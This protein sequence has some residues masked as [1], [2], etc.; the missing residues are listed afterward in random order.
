MRTAKDTVKKVESHSESIWCPHCGEEFGIESVIEND[1]ELQA[2]ISFKAGREEEANELKTL[3]Q[4]AYRI[5]KAFDDSKSSN[6]YFWLQQA[7][8]DTDEWEDAQ[9]LLNHTIAMGSR[10]LKDWGELEEET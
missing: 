10:K 2:E 7:F 6:V 4:F 1:R 5:A 3:V 9:D 8:C